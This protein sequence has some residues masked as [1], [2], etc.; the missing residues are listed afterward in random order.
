VRRLALA[1]AT[2]ACSA[3]I[4]WSQT[5]TRGPLLQNPDRDATKATF[6]WWTNSAGNSTVEYG[7]T[8][9]LGQSVTIPQAG[10]CDV[11]SAGTCHT[12]TVSDLAPE[13]LYYYR[14]LTNG[15]PVTSTTYFTTL[16]QA[17]VTT[18]HFFTVIGDWGQGTSQQQQLANL[19]NAADTPMILTVGDNTYT[20]GF[21]SELDSNA[22]ALYTS[23]LPR[24]FF[25]PALG[26][27]DLNAVF[28]NVNNYGTTAYART[29]VLP[30][31]A[32]AQPERYYSF[33]SGQVH[34]TLIDTDSCCDA[35]Q[36]AWLQNDLATSTAT[37]KFV[38]LHHAPYSCASGSASFG[39]N[40]SVR[41]AWGPLFEQYGVDVVFIGHD[42]IYER[43]VFVDDYQVGGAAGSD[44]LGT[45]YVM[46]GGGGAAL[47]G[48]AQLSGGIPQRGGSPCYWLAQSCPTGPNGYCSLATYQYTS[49]EIVNDVMTLEGIDNAGSVFDTFVIDKSGGTTTTTSTSSTTTTSTST[50]STTSTSSSTSSTT[51]TSTSTSSTT[52]TTATTTSTS[53]STSSTTSTSTSSTSSTSTSTSS[54]TT[55]STSS[56]TTTSSSSS[57]TTSTST[58]TTLVCPDVDGDALCDFVDPCINATSAL[59]PKL[60][61]TRLLPPPADEILKVKG[62]AVIPAPIVPPL[63]PETDGVRVVLTDGLGTTLI[64]AT[65]PPGLRDATGTGWVARPTS[66]SWQSLTGVQG[67][68]LV[69]FKLSA[70]GAGHLAFKI[71]AKNATLPITAGDLPLTATLVLDPPQATTGRC[72]D[73]RFPGPLGVAP[74]CVMDGAATKVRCR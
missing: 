68:R 8:P 32:P 26:N 59:K 37:W 70:S 34:H 60:I 17:G 53:S 19:Q 46:T 58:S 36:T 69:K 55:T 6:V 12:V 18:D 27:H 25:F 33:D 67:V 45:Y 47:D 2:L 1:L 14:L 71:L 7:L 11:G 40:L 56:S 29:F 65:I 44:G 3:S 64:D 30:R 9:A 43:S 5:I 21:Q 66:W 57:T 35:T 74:T 16:A 62:T 24:A 61:V 15:V 72:G 52:S 31:N 54:T 28:G 63:H 20:F 73:A 10:S 23:I 39:S 49:V 50:S 42:H 22:L 13:T 51:S 4:G 38:Y 41:N 48:A